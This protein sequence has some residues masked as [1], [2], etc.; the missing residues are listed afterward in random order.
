MILLVA[1]AA[2]AAVAVSRPWDDQGEKRTDTT[3]VLRVRAGPYHYWGKLGPGQAYERAVAAFGVP[4]ARGTTDP[5]STT[6]TVRWESPGVD[7]DF[8]GAAGCGDA[9]L[10]RRSSWLGMRLWGTGWKTASGLRVGDSVRRIR[11]LYPRARYVSKPPT[12]GHWE[13]VAR[14]SDDFGRVPL[15]IAQVGADRVTA[16]DVPPGF[17][18]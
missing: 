8:V 11:Q 17:V 10:R 16:I 5:M 18:F 12:P 1:G 6:C 15:L 4:S 2:L 14:R 3:L 7:V 13:L 9:E